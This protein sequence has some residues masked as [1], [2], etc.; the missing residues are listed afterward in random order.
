L[1]SAAFDAPNATTLNPAI[2]GSCITLNLTYIQ[3]T[4][5]DD[6]TRYRALQIYKRRTVD[7]TLD[8]LEKMIE[9]MPFS[10][11]RIQTDSGM[12]FFSEKVQ[13]RLMEYCIKSCPTDLPFL[14]YKR[15]S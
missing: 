15:K 11:Q 2:S 8:F 7:N 6:C 12:E 3:Y 13:R 10:I 14:I 5:I 4:A 1:Y 9:Q